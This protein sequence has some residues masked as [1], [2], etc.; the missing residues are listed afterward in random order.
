M[1]RRSAPASGARA[2][3]R[4][5]AMVSSAALLLG[6]RGPAATSF[7]NV[8]ASSRAPRGSIYH[9][10]P[11]GKHELIEAAVRWTSVEVLR[12]QRSC[13]ARSPRGIIGHFVAYF[14]RAL[15]ASACRTGCPVAAVVIGSR[16]E[17]PALARSVRTTFRAWV[18]L[19]TRQ[20][21]ASGLPARQARRLA[22]AAVA[23]V[24]GALILARVESSTEALD[25]IGDRLAPQ[26]VDRTLPR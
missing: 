19:L 25:A 26:R 24:E 10:F 20:L 14:R 9:Y 15:V 17:S 4:R 5:A 2:G 13:A 3:R 12:H 8:L 22:L 6:S 11:G 18:G 7:A 23:G 16:A 1:T 21:A